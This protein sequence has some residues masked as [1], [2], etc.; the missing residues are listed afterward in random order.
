MSAPI[1]PP[2]ALAALQR[3]IDGAKEAA[4]GIAQAAAE[5]EAPH[6]PTR[7]ACMYLDM[8]HESTVSLREAIN[9]LHSLSLNAVT[10]RRKVQREV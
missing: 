2:S 1:V 7:D 5:C 9:R 4:A 6:G 8:L 10:D 3:A